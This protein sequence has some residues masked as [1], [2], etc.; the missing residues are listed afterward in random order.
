[1]KLYEFGPTRAL[2][3]RWVL[4]ELEIP[5]EAEAVNLPK[6]ENRS[7]E[8]LKVNPAGKVPALVDGDVVLTE[9]VAIALY[10]AEKYPAKKLLPSDSRERAQLDRWL[11]FVMTE[12]EQPLWRIVKHQSLYPPERRIPAE[13]ENASRDF[14]EVAPVLETH[15]TGRDYLVGSRVSVGDFVTAYTL[16]WAN[17]AKLLDGFPQLVR[18]MNRMYARPHAPP[19]IA[20]EFARIR[21]A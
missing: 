15:M 8:F 9:S 18:Y 6:G 20:T 5:F 4:Q 16:D 14:T 17:E 21:A 11:Y 13:I 12:L 2:R 1:M 10:L 7:P 3:D 19:R